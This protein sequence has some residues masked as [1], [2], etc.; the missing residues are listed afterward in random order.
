MQVLAAAL[1][2]YRSVTKIDLGYNGITD[3]GAKACRQRVA[4][5]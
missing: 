2:Q 3:E 5:L 4:F 1:R